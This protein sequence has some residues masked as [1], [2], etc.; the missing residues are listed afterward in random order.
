MHLPDGTQTIPVQATSPDQ[1]TS[2]T[3]T[4]TLTR[5]TEGQPTEGRQTPDARPKEMPLGS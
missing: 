1:R 4:P 3:I 2:R 5:Q